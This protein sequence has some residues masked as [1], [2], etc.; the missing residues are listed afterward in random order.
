MGLLQLGGIHAIVGQIKGIFKRLFRGKNIRHQK[1]Q[2]TPQFHQMIGH[3][4][5]R[6]NQA[7]FRMEFAYG[8]GNVSIHAL[9]AMSFIQNDQLIILPRPI[10]RERW[11]LDHFVRGDNDIVIPRG[12]V[13]KLRGG[14]MFRIRGMVQ[15]ILEFRSPLRNFV[16]PRIQHGQGTNDEIGTGNILEF[17]TFVIRRYLGGSLFLQMTNQ[18][19][20][21]QSLPESHFI[22]QNHAHIMLV[23]KGHPFQ[24]L[25]LIIAHVGR[26]QIGLLMQ[27]GGDQ[28]LGFF[29]TPQ[30]MFLHDPC[31]TKGSQ[32]TAVGL[33]KGPSGRCLLPNMISHELFLLRAH[34]FRRGGNA[35]CLLGSLLALGFFGGRR[36][37]MRLVKL[38]MDIGETLNAIIV[39]L[40]D[41]IFS[42]VQDC[43]CA[44]P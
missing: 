22:S 14:I 13:V 6:Q 32:G 30:A 9:D 2:Q 36:S 7:R 3:G 17:S 10:M 4:G 24:S 12:H 26:N 27:G 15:K 35:R 42:N 44:D 20:R 38:S 37:R 1:I 5:T 8:G 18:G 39:F 21:L 34:S 28:G 25:Q 40:L 23:H 31:F 16:T 41:G 11:R 19:Y 33:Q 43:G 29:A